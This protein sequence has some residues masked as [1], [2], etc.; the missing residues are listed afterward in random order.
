M[1]KSKKYL[2]ASKIKTLKSCSWLYWCKY[3]LNLPEASNDGARRGTVCHLVFEVLGNPRHRHHYDDLIDE[4]SLDG[5]PAVKRLVRRNCMKLGVDDKDN[6]ELIEEM[7]FAGLK[8]DF[9]GDKVLPPCEAFSEYDFCIEKE[10][11]DIKYNVVGFI[12]KLFAYDDFDEIVIRDFKTSKA[13]FDGKDLTD[14]LQDWIYSL[15]SKELFPDYKNRECEFLFLKFMDEK[16]Y[17]DGVA[18]MK[19]LDD[20]DLEAFEYE[21]THYQNTIENFSYND[22]VSNYAAEQG[23]PTDNSF[24]GRLKCGFAKYKGQLKKDGAKMW[25]CP[26]KFEFDYYSIIN[27]DGDIVRNVLEDEFDES[28]VGENEI[29][30]KAKYDGC[31]H[32]KK[33]DK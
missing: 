21:L 8:H 15:A 14:N 25:H 26:F 22:A 29:Y 4:D 1:D 23:F 24:S 32:W 18:K 33:F 6:M 10:G 16:K 12:D 20:V 5:S 28:M 27:E 9:F 17:D 11:E 31:P 19:P 2:S 30:V 3:V 7:I 13:M